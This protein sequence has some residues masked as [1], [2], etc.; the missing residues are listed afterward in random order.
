[1]GFAETFKALSDPV[2]REIL[3]LLKRPIARRSNACRNGNTFQ[4]HDTVKRFI[5]NFRYRQTAIRL[6]N[7]DIRSLRFFI[8]RNF[9]SFSTIDKIKRKS[10]HLFRNCRT[11][12]YY[13]HTAKR[14]QI[15]KNCTSLS[16]LRFPRNGENNNRPCFFQ[17]GQLLAA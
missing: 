17:G 13:R 14:N 16:V 6:R 9:V 5:R 7:H 12:A 1:M 11:G 3:T 2:R 8:I 15:G 10:F 4:I